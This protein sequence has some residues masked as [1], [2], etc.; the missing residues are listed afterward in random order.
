MFNKVYLGATPISKI[1]LG[2]VPIK[3]GNNIRAIYT[4]DDID[5]TSPTSVTGKADDWE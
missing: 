4:V 5:Y 2:D 1:F 3:Y